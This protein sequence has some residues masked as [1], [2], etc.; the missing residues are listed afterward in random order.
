MTGHLPIAGRLRSHPAGTHGSAL[1][2]V[3]LALG[4]LVLL[5]V[6]LGQAVASLRDVGYR[7]DRQAVAPA[8]AISAASTDRWTWGSPAIMEAHVEEQTLRVVAG[9]TPGEGELMVGLWVDGRKVRESS[10]TG[11]REL[12]FEVPPLSERPVEVSVRARRPGGPWGV[13][14]QATRSPGGTIAPPGD[15][16]SAPGLLVVH[17]PSAGVGIVRVA[18]A[19]EE[20][21]TSSSA[22]PA[23]GPCPGGEVIEVSAAG[24]SQNLITRSGGSTHVYF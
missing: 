14:W 24:R 21:V 4:L 20:T 5:V 19:A 16:A 12:V 22:S 15:A 10:T 2:E 9:A 7:L 1:L 13:A 23:A 11:G 6:A 8:S 3:V 18:G 17:L